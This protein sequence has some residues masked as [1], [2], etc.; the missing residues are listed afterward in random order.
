QWGAYAIGPIVGRVLEIPRQIRPWMC[1]H[2]GLSA[3]RP[4]D[5]ERS[6]VLVQV[7]I[8]AREVV[9]PADPDGCTEHVCPA[10]DRCRAVATER[11]PGD[12]QSIHVDIAELR[13]A[14]H[15]WQQLVDHLVERVSG[16]TIWT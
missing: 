15:L 2:A 4:A 13:R 9:D 14:V 11:L 8:G 16:L 1:A 5:P 12:R 3:L 6:A 10:D 7:P